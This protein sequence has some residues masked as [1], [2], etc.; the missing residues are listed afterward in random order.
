LLA[1]VR[2]RSSIERRDIRAGPKSGKHVALHIAARVFGV[3][4]THATS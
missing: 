4:N 2:D 3:N 1:G